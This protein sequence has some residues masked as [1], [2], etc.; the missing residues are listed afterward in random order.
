MDENW[1]QPYFGEASNSEILW[2]FTQWL[3]SLNLKNANTCGG[4]RKCHNWVVILTPSAACSREPRVTP[5][6]ATRHHKKMSLEAHLAMIVPFLS[7]FGFDDLG[8]GKDWMTLLLHF[9]GPILYI[10]YKCLQV[11]DIPHTLHHRSEV[12]NDCNNNNKTWVSWFIIMFTIIY[13]IFRHI[14][15]SDLWCSGSY[16]YQALPSYLLLC[17]TRWQKNITPDSSSPWTHNPFEKQLQ[18]G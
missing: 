5:R 12:P 18:V 7:I 2:D 15:K 9:L 14:K 10:S 8:M 16:P 3:A 6:Y 13:P 17:T 1:G 11:R 4:M